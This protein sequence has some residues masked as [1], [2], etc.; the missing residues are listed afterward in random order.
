MVLNELFNLTDKVAIVTGAQKWL[1]HDMAGIL[2][3][4]GA[5]V[6]I[7]S[8]NLQSASDAAAKA[9]VLG[10]TRDLAG[11]LSPQGICV[12]A[13]SPGEFLKPGDLPDEFV[14]DLADGTMTGRWGQ[15]GK[16][17]KGTA[18]F[19]ASPASDH[20]TAQNLVVDGG[21]SLWK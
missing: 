6:I 17:I 16:D 4:A 14:D 3:E 9:G 8:R 7:T 21:F 12:N 20:V 18:L 1:G 11:L 5:D 2:A 15:M 19:L 13:I 10:L